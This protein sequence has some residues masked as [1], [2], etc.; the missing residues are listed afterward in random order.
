MYE[1]GH[2]NPIQYYC[3]ENPLDREAWWAIGHRVA[4]SPTQL[5]RLSMHAM[6]CIVILLWLTFCC[7]LYFLAKILDFNIPS[8]ILL[9]LESVKWIS[10]CSEILGVHIMLGCSIQLLSRVQL[11]ATPW[12]AARQAS[13]S[14][15]SSQRLPKLMSIESVMLPNHLILHRPLLLLPSV[16]PNIRVF[17]NESALRMRWPKY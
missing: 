13:L 6:W 17:S 8:R 5:K 9:F 15:T 10:V 4:K 3:L 7:M 12:T 1:G 14:I 16:F 11:F 2:D